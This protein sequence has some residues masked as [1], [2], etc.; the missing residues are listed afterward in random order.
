MIRTL[1]PTDT[2]SVCSN[3]DQHGCAHG[4]F[5]CACFV[6][7]PITKFNRANAS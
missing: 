5:C 4:V 3:E 1:L 2:N 6:N 7:A